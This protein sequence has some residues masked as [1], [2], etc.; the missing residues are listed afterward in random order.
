MKTTF[1]LNHDHI[2]LSL[3]HLDKISNSLNECEMMKVEPIFIE[4]KIE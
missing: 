4:K 1:Y 2:Q 3:R